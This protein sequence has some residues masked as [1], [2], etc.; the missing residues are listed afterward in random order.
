MKATELTPLQRIEILEDVLKKLESRD[1]GG[2]LC[3][4]IENSAIELFRILDKAKNI[5]SNF[6]FE[7]ARKV[8]RVS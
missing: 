2:G 3:V 8:R 5:I 1:D 6:T 7:N 4:K